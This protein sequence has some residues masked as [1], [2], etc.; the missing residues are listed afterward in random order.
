ML[1]YCM[2]WTA[3]NR[4]QHLC[5]IFWCVKRIR[6]VWWLCI[7]YRAFLTPLWNPKKNRVVRRSIPLIKFKPKFL[8]CCHNWCLNKPFCH[9]HMLPYSSVLNTELNYKI[10]ITFSN[11]VAVDLVTNNSEPWCI[12]AGPCM[13]LTIFCG[14]ATIHSPP[15]E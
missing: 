8:L 5:N 15:A 11:S 1:D 2:S 6:S 12:S 3:L 14:A 13:M 9:R 4:C 10:T 7:L